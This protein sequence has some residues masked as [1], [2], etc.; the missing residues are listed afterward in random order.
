M[1]LLGHLGYRFVTVVRKRRRSYRARRDGFALTICFDE[2]ERVGHFIE[3][4][5]LVPEGQ[6]DEAARVLADTAASLNLTQVET[7]SYLGMVLDAEARAKGEGRPEA[8][9]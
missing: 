2:V 4:E 5:I 7:R 6:E 1:R 3:L 9:P 8:S